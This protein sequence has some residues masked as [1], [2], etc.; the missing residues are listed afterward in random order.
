MKIGFS[1]NLAA[2]TAQT[3]YSRA[4]GGS[5]T[6]VARLSSGERITNASDDVASLSIATKISAKLSG[7]R[8]ARQNV[9]QAD[10]LLQVADQALAQITNIL[11]RQKQLA[12]RAASGELS[13]AERGFLS[14]EFVGLRDELDRLA[15]QTSF[16]NIP[17]FSAEAFNN[18]VLA[19]T[20]TQAANAILATTSLQVTGGG[21]AVSSSVAIQAFHTQTGASLAGIAAAGQLQFVD[22]GGVV[23][24]DAAFASV[25]Q[26]AYGSFSDFGLSEVVYGPAGRGA[27]TLTASLNGVEYSGRLVAGNNIRVILSN[28]DTHIQMHVGNVTLQTAGQVQFSEKS[29]SDQFKFTTIARTSAVNGVNFFGTALDGVVGDAISG[30]ANIRLNEGPLQSIGNF[31]YL[32]NRNT[33]NSNTLSVEINGKTFVANNVRDQITAGSLQFRDESR[34]QVLSLNFTGLGANITNIR[35]RP[36][37]RER[38][39]DALNQGFA[40]ISSSLGFAVGD[41]TDQ[42]I[43][44]RL[45][46][47]SPAALMDG[48]DVAISTRTQAQFASEK[49]D[50]A[51]RRVT[52]LRAE[53]GAVTS[54]LGFAGSVVDVSIQNQEAARSF[55]ADT[56]IAAT[57]SDFAL[58]QARLGYAGYALAQANSIPENLLELLGE[59]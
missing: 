4:V 44:V 33:A 55:L 9:T 25:N 14:R 32:G 1:E 28:G 21:N 48:A 18:T 41:T 47:A 15:E 10:S 38:F 19:Q 29:I 26:S 22:A 50:G 5:A 56:D 24:S 34:L 11:Q 42:R 6:S 40:N 46:D 27:A 37:D 58:S 43:D 2:R 52:S 16:N 45:A 12:V 31:Q 53:I 36:L 51:I 35:T 57:S 7:L 39:M 49:L 23:L 8:S 13:D 17:L 3:S 54:R 59:A 20:N 30:I